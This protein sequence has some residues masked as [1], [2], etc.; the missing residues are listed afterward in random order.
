MRS[1]GYQ[2]CGIWYFRNQWTAERIVEE[3]EA[4]VTPEDL[5]INTP[6]ECF[7][8]DII[9]DG[10]LIGRTLKTLQIKREWIDNSLKEYGVNDYNQVFYA[11]V[12]DNMNLFVQKKGEYLD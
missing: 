5:N 11:S 7:E 12:D 2:R 6:Q 3:S 4:P 9:I 1:S 10:K 8:H